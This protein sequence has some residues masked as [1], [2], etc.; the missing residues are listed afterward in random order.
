[1]R[2]LFLLGSAAAIAFGAWTFAPD[3]VAGLGNGV[4]RGVC[5]V[6]PDQC[7]NWHRASLEGTRQ[8]LLEHRARIQDGVRKLEEHAAQLRQ[9]LDLIKAN[10]ALLAEREVQRRARNAATLDFAGATYS[11]TDVEAQARLLSAEQAQYEGILANEVATRRAQFAEARENVSLAY[12]RIDSV[13]QMLAADAALAPVTRDLGQVR[14]LASAA[15]MATQE[16]TKL[17][18]PV[19]SVLELPPLPTPTVAAATPPAAQPG[20]DLDGW[21]R[22]N[23]VLR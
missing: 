9:R 8:R 18:D 23:V 13:V 11:A 20:F 16:A 15:D 19:R 12:S 7:L 6:M 10:S 5:S 17:L 14:R 22:Q 3:A 21:L 2:K 1:M 4:M